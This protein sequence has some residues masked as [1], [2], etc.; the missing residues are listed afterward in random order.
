MATILVVDDLASHRQLAAGLLSR[1]PGYEV[2]FAANG[3]EAL[4]KLAGGKA[5]VILTDVL[6]PEMDGLELL[7]AVR[8]DY[9]QLPVVLMTASGSEHIAVQALQEGAASY[10]PKRVLARRLA[11]TVASVL[12]ASRAERTH[13]ELGKRL[14]SQVLTFELENDAELLL[15]LATYLKPYLVAAGL[16]DHLVRLRIHMALEEALLNA[17]C[18]GNLEIGAAMREKGAD[19]LF[20]LAA[21]RAKE[22]PYHE[23]RIY[24]RVSL[25]ADQAEFTIRDEGPGFD[26]ATL[27]DSADAGSLDQPHGRGVMLMRTFMDE[28]RYNETGNEVT[29]IKR[30]K[31]ASRPVAQQ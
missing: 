26:P 10:V 7:R 25:S 22:S 14:T 17:L 24:V 27:P 6:M 12:A 21:S 13:S 19:D 8:R 20:Q 11:E 2:L 4:A 28:V 1:E 29:M 15:A 31:T 16:T 9:P 18:H 23:R 5:D 30:L 3:A